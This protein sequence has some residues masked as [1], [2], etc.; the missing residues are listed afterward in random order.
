MFAFKTL[1]L[2]SLFPLFFLLGCKGICNR[3]DKTGGG[4][5]SAY[6]LGYKRCSGCNLYIRFDGLRCPCCHYPLRSK[7]R[8]HRVTK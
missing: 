4:Y 1:C 7:R 6:I 3:Y 5:Q 8:Y 2:C